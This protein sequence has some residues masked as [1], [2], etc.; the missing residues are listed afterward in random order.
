MAEPDHRARAAA[1]MSALHRWYRPW[2]GRWRTTGWWNAANA[3]TAVIAYTQRTG[4]R[5]YARVID[6]TFTGA[7]RR[8]GDFIVRYFDD[9]MWWGLAWVA[10]YDLTG[11]SRYLDAARKIFAHAET[12]WDDTCGGGVWW[13]QD[14]KYKNA[15][16]NEQFLTL[17]ARLHQRVPGQDGYYLK[18]ALREWEWFSSTGMIGPSG[19][20]NDGLTPDCQNNGGITWTYNQGVILGGLAAMHEITGDR[21]YLDQGET[22]AGAALRELTTPP[23]A[24]PP[25]ILVEPKEMDTRPDDGDRPQFKGIFVRNLYDFFLQSRRPAYREFILRNARSIWDNDR[26]AGNQFGLHWSGPFDQADA[27]RQ[28]S[29]LDALNAAI[30]L[31]AAP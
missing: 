14:R 15:I 7:W 13:N 11:E 1:G 23:P 20:V 29:A 18:W 27:C 4:D 12:G 10:A 28:S 24:D 3:L 8:H 26:N 25:G 6:R 22:I 17:A 5:S 30:P 9:N 31:A 16:T 2:S 19:L 21:A